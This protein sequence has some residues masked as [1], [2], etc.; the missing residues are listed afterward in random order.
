MLWFS[1][2]VSDVPLNLNFLVFSKRRVFSVPVRTV[3]EELSVALRRGA[4]MLRISRL[5]KV[6]LTDGN[7]QPPTHLD[8]DLTG[9]NVGDT[10]RLDRVRFPAG[11]APAPGVKQDHLVGVIHGNKRG[12][13]EE[14]AAADT[15]DKKKKK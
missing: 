2:T 10:V 5:I 7:V 1:D 11:V 12:M 8:V 9:V 3:N 4:F 13:E 14:K 6:V 15:K